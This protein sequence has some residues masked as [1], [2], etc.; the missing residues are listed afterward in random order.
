MNINLLSSQGWPPISLCINNN[1]GPKAVDC[2]KYL[3]S[4]GADINV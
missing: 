2:L 4:K 1:I 3:I